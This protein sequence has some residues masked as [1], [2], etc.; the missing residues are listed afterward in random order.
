VKATLEDGR[1]I[2]GVAN[3]G[4]R[5]TVA[6]STRLLEVHLFDF[7]EDLYGQQCEVEFEEHL[8]NEMKFPSIDALRAQIE[9]DADAA[10]K[11]LTQQA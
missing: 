11:V 10:K 7:S 9:K 3:L 5:P 6:G 1:K 8:R 4:M 2:G